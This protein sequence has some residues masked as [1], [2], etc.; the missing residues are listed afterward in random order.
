MLHEDDEQFQP[1]KRQLP[2][3]RRLLREVIH[4]FGDRLDMAI[5]PV[6][7]NDSNE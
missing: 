4:K 5:K 7:G 6:L 2:V 3:Q 1:T